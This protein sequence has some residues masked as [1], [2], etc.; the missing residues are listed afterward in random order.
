MAIRARRDPRTAKFR[1]LST[2]ASDRFWPGEQAGDERGAEED[3]A[4]QRHGAGG[5]DGY[6][7]GGGGG[8]QAGGDADDGDLPAL[9]APQESAS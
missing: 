5:Y 9:D 6:G 3:A 7:G 8:W 4:W 1:I 2:T